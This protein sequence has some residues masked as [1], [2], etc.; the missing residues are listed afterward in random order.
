[1]QSINHKCAIDTRAI[2]DFTLKFLSQQLNGP[3]AT[4]PGFT[5][6]FYGAA[7]APHG[8]VGPSNQSINYPMSMPPP[9]IFGSFNGAAIGTARLN[10][11]L[12]IQ[13]E[14]FHLFK[15]NKYIGKKIS[16]NF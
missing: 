13:V 8:F 14:S 3:Y 15:Q 5:E 10:W 1:M 7:P 2:V 6:N 4:R 12:N 9:E 16:R 11:Q